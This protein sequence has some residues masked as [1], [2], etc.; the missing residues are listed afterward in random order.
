MTYKIVP[1]LL[2]TD[3]EDFKNDLHRVESFA[4]YAQIDVMDGVFVPTKSFSEIDE[5][6]NLKSTTK[7]ELHL[8]VEHPLVELKKWIDVKNIFRVI[9]HIEL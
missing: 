2:R 1:A 4:E 9:F 5:I 8:M 7:F 6:N 3:F